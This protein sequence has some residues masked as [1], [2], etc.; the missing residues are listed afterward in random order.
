MVWDDK[1][2]VDCWSAGRDPPR[3]FLLSRVRVAGMLAF[4][5]VGGWRGL[6]VGAVSAGP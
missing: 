6:G 1:A 3:A 2:V 4:A 5:W